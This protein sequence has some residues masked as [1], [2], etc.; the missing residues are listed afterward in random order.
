MFNGGPTIRRCWSTSL[1]TENLDHL[2]VATQDRLHQPVRDRAMLS[3]HEGHHGG[4]GPTRTLSGRSALCPLTP[5][6][7]APRSSP[8]HPAARVRYHRLRTWPRRASYRRSLWEHVLSPFVHRSTKFGDC[9]G[10][11]LRAVNVHSAHEW[12]QVLE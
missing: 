5:H 10:A 2:A 6:R 7:R 3:P 8:S 12:R 1:A 11:M 9:E 4:V